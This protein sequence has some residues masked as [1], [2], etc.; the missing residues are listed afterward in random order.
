MENNTVAWYNK[1]WVV[2]VSLIFCFPVGLFVLWRNENISK[3]WKAGVTGLLVILLGS[4]YLE[5]QDRIAKKKQFDRYFT[6][7]NS[8]SFSIDK[9]F[10]PEAARKSVRSC[11][12][13]VSDSIRNA[14]ID[15]EVKLRLNESLDS[16]GK[17][18]ESKITTWLKEEDERQK[19]EKEKRKQEAI[20]RAANE[21]ASVIN[22]L[23]GVF[24]GPFGTHEFLQD[25][26]FIYRQRSMLGVPASSWRGKWSYVGGRKVQ[27]HETW[28]NRTKI[29]TVKPDCMISGIY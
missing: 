27:M 20:K 29:L 23:I 25:G 13:S 19:K 6:Q 9:D 26:T 21:K 7:M 1:T 15:S 11:L 2:V 16:I 18:S 28:L 17:V 12:K 5:N 4:N 24:K 8:C 22:C 14:A 10:D 3:M